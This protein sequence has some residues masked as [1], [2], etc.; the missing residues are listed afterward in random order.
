MCQSVAESRSV[1]QSVAA[2]G[3]V[4]QGVAE[5]C[6]S[7][8]DI[9]EKHFVFGFLFG[10]VC[11]THT[12]MYTSF[13][14]GAASVQK[15]GKGGTRISIGTLNME[16]YMTNEDFNRLTLELVFMIR[17]FFMCALW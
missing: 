11:V 9:C 10:L 14:P 2:C 17:V 5:L 8:C 12:G 3:S 7:E 13:D 1:S 15:R 6:F 4:W 16:P